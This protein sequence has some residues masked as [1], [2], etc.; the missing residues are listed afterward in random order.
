M[1]VMFSLCKIIKISQINLPSRCENSKNLREYDRMDN[2]CEEHRNEYTLTLKLIVYTNLFGR[3]KK[4]SQ[5]L[6]QGRII[7]I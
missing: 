1:Y 7:Y 6:L 2:I 5:D 3:T 4:H